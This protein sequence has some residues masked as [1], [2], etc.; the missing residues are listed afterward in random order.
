MAGVKL[1]YLVRDRDRHGNVRMYVRRPGQPKIRIGV[2]ESSAEF[3]EA[4][5]AALRGERWAVAP[6]RK[7][8]AAKPSKA[9]PGSFR[10]LCEAYYGS[11]EFKR[12]TDRTRY[13]R[14]RHFEAVF[15]EPLKPGS[16]LRFADCPLRS[17]RAAHIRVL[18]DRRADKPEAA[19]DRLKALRTVLAY[20]VATGQLD[21]NPARDVPRIKTAS[22]GFRTWTRDEIAA[23]EVRHPV[24][25]K[26]RLAFALLLYTGQRRSDV[27]TLGPAMVRDEVLHFTQAKNAG[28]KPVA[29]ALPIAP[30]LRT[31]L[32][33]SP[34]GRRTFLETE[35]G[36]PF[37]VAGF[38]N[39]FRDR[40]NEAGLTGVSAHGLRKALQAIGAELGLTDR[41]LMAIAGHAT[42]KETTR[43]TAAAERAKLA[44]AGMEKLVAG[45]FGTESVPPKKSPTK[46]PKKPS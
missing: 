8:A 24:G 37:A 3:V 19:N 22:A 27:V 9:L 39:W 42:A 5:A 35:L 11:A 23:F 6:V 12:L 1:P 34:C 18:R 20:A 14:R 40:C 10:A 13:V 28:R 4:Y 46:P 45:R 43:Y 38:G 33:A 30:A 2:P 36:K 29:M 16:E 31:I 26:A 25:S 32:D 21:A 15:D 7:R 41:E 17:L 44:K